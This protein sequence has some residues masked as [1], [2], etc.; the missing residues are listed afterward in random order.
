MSTE[1]KVLIKKMNGTQATIVVLG[2]AV[3]VAGPW[4]FSTFLAEEKE[5]KLEEL[6]TKEHIA[7]L[8]KLSFANEQQVAVQKEMVSALRKQGD[9]GE[10]VIKMAEATNDALLKAAS[11]TPESII[12]GA[13]ISGSDAETLRHTAR[14]RSETHL[15]TQQVTVISIAMAGQT[16][17][18]VFQLSSPDEQHKII[19]PQTL[20]SSE[21]RT[22][23]Y[24]AL[25]SR[26]SIWV[27][28]SIKTIDGQI[29]SVEFLRVTEPPKQVTQTNN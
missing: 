2:I 15:A 25:Q 5:F 17:E 28:I 9:I 27:E 24:G 12:N 22:K 1:P 29:R 18:F 13:A 14:K 20:F 23:L 8:E 16:D 10:R 19:L 6:R 7:A 21:D 4:S 26:A 3:L 11:K